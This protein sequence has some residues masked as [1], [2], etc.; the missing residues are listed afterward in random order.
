MTSSFGVYREPSH[1][2]QEASP[3]RPIAASGAPVMETIRQIAQETFEEKEN[4]PRTPRQVTPAAAPSTPPQKKDASPQYL[5]LSSPESP[6]KELSPPPSPSF[7]RPSKS[8]MAL[9]NPGQNA[10]AL[11]FDDL[12]PLK[13]PPAKKKDAVQV[14]PVSKFIA[15]A[16]QL[17]PDHTAVRKTLE[18]QDSALTSAYSRPSPSRHE[19]LE[20]LEDCARNAMRR[21]RILRFMSENGKVSGVLGWKEFSS[22]WPAQ[23]FQQVNQ[24]AKPGKDPARVLLNLTHLDNLELTEGGM[25]VKGK[26][27]HDQYL[28]G[29]C[30]N[31]KTQVW[32]ALQKVEGCMKEAKF[33]TF[34]PL[35]R[36]S[37]QEIIDLVTAALKSPV[38]AHKGGL[39]L[40]QPGG[41]DYCVEIAMHNSIISTV[42]PILDYA[43][44][45]PNAVFRYDTYRDGSLHL[46]THQIALKELL[47]DIRARIKADSPEIRYQCDNG[48]L[49]IDIAYF[50]KDCPIQKGILVRFPRDVVLK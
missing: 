19:A 30:V 43:V 42:I 23:V 31:R 11:D 15:H 41:C 9:R 33:S 14:T 39:I 21:S 17:T 32:C 26:H 34:F 18:F 45:E 13:T 25:S 28:P 46:S 3:S 5:S 22:C 47:P 40:V 44:Y 37:H 12:K 38:I 24:Q 16:N 8:R 36:C 10:I 35:L 49:I 6:A 2:K 50:L 29:A 4:L 20:R 48:D 7:R 27:I 1:Q